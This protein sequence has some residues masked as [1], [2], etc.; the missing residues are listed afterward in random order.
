MDDYAKKITD[1]GCEIVAPK[2][3]IPTVGYIAY[4]KDTEG[5]VVGIYQDDSEAA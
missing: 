4:F 1:A 3:A 2:M 5:N